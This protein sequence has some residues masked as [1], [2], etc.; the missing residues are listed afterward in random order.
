MFA[1]S[2]NLE[3][4]AGHG[5]TFASAK[6]LKNLKGIKE[7]NIGHFIVSESVFYGLEEVIKRFKR[8]IG[9]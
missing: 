5:L 1:N 8:I 7:F 6:V 4:H 9:S 2:I 3:T